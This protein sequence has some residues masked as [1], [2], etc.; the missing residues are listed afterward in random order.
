MPDRTSDL[1]QL[2]RRLAEG[3][4]QVGASEAHGILS[5]L[6]CADAVPQSLNALLELFAEPQRLSA[7]C[8]KSLG[9]TLLAL[10]RDIHRGLG[11]GFTEEGFHF[12]PLLPEDEAPIAERAAALGAWCRGFVLGLSR[13]G[14]DRPGKLS[15]DGAEALRDMM[16]IC[17]AREEPAFGESGECG[18][19]TETDLAYEELRAYVKIGVQLIF[20]QARRPQT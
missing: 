15:G 19:Q 14:L 17:G 8:K 10:L 16:A 9:E 7:C 18:D 4:A 6:V 13:G 20:D 12:A 3:E 11:K 5:G 2:A 1:A